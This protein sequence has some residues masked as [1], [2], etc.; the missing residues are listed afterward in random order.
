MTRVAGAAQVEG[1]T[2]DRTAP[3]ASKALN[4]S[5]PRAPRH[6][7]SLVGLLPVGRKQYTLTGNYYNIYNNTF[8][9]PV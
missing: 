5:R 9:L 6:L 4:K 1:G 7:M 2:L 3:P 8:L